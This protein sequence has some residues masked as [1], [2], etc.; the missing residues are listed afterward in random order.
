V[1]VGAALRVGVARLTAAGVPD[2][3]G[4]ARRL[5]AFALGCDPSRLTL[6]TGDLIA[7]ETAARWEAAI[8]ARSSRQP[9]AQIVGE[10][11]FWG[12]AFR[13]TRDTLDP[14]PET[15]TLVAEALARPFVRVLDLGTGTGAILVSLLAER[16]GA[17]GL[18]T[19]VSKA[20]LAVAAENAARYGVEGRA[21]F[22][23]SDWFSG[24]EGEFDLIVSNP[25]YIAEAELAGLAPEVRNW[26]PRL[27]LSPGGDG[28]GAYRAIAAV[29]PR[30]LARG[31][32]LLVE[33]G[34]TQAGA[35]GG[36]FAE[37]GLCH[38][39]VAQDLDGR[40]RVVSGEAI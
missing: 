21:G 35:V 14:R 36:L 32:R 3:A 2:A 4:D 16:E 15:E 26:E 11:L 8:V 31:G 34:P 37:A 40:D 6:L 7:A 30:H 27:A 22:L 38:I 19:D 29:A 17:S 33:I 10:R 9:V 13:V 25:P 5:M 18:G 39:A 12:R 28:L 20:A 24:V 1:T 23:M